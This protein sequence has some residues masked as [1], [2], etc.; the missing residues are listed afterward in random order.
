MAD[1]LHCTL[2]GEPMQL[3]ADRAL[4]WPARRRLFVADLHLGKGDAFRS[5]GIA[6]PSGGTLHD[7]ARISVLVDAS[8]ATSL[9]VLGDFLHAAA[10][11]RR[12]RE[13]WEAWRA[14][15]PDLEFAVLAGNHDRALGALGLDVALPG[16]AVDD[17]PF[18]LRHAPEPRASRHVLCG[19]LHPTLRLPGLPGRWPAYWLRGHDTVLPAFSR[20]TGGRTPECVPGQRL[21]ACV[22]GE[23]VEFAAGSNG[24][25][26]R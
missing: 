24:E 10:T 23:L 12:W 4:Y 25:R 3:F 7:L 16:A 26:P 20:F 13:G 6:L 19:H 8:G 9:W 21:V 18:A 1:R 11:E 17:G 5:A 22:H 15:H 14:R 2:A